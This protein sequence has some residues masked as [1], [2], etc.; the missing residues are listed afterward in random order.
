MSSNTVALENGAEDETSLGDAVEEST[1]VDPRALLVDWANGNDEWIRLLI[2]EVIST[3]RPVDTSTFEKAYQLFHQEKALDKR[4]L[5]A[6]PK[7]NFEARQD[8][9]APPLT[10]TRLS[11][12]RGVNALTPGAVI[13]LHE[14]LTILYG[15][16]GTGK[17]GYPPIFKALANS[18]TADT[19]LGNIDTDTAEAQS[20]TLEFKLGD[21]T[22]T[23]TWTGDRGLSPF[24]RMSIFDSPAVRTHVYE[25]LDYVYTPASLAL[26]NDVTTAIQAVTVRINAA[27]ADLGSS[28]SGLLTRFQRGSTVSRSSRRL[29]CPPTWLTSYPRPN[30]AMPT[31]RNLIR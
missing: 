27:I 11:G 3:G 26:F 16:N 5:P 24:T 30:P 20:A 9:S 29:A 23:L 8:E 6:V 7:L 1:S 14:G 21:D 25:D 28:G 31:R 18:R 15:G 13:E 12:V 10:L 2:S 22:Q 19:I 17:T 4:E